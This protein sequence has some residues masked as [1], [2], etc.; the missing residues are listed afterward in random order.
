LPPDVVGNAAALDVYKFLRLQV[1]GRSL[2]D[3]AIA[4]ETTLAAALSD[5]A[6]LAAEWMA[7]FAT[8]P[9]P[10]GQPATHKLAKQ[11]YWPLGEK[12]YHLLA[13]LFP[14][15]LVQVMWASIREDRFSDEAK[16]A[17][18]AKWENRAHPQG[19]RE[20][21]D[22]AIQHFGG[23]KPQNIS[24]LNSER[25]GE[26]WLLPSLPPTW[27]SDPIRPPFFTESAFARR[28]G[29]RVAVK[30]LTR[31]LR[32]FLKSVAKADSNIRIRNKRAEL[33]GYIRDE[34]FQFAAE[35]HELD[36]GWSQDQ[37]CRLN[38]AEQCWLDSKRA[39]IDEEFAARR[40][41]G[42]WQ[43]E[44]CLRFSNWLNAALSA[45]STPMGQA[46]S[47]AWQAVLEAELRSMR[48]ELADHD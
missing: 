35:L 28:F 13:P 1:D 15:S 5:D 30:Q 41:R 27:Q 37:R 9:D 33:V 39:A 45:D 23:T 4:R 17:R 46:E 44:V 36:A 40:R 3:R 6:D 32:E 14:T 25:H 12:Q 38:A 34:L 43:D 7:A 10:N 8:L 42:D 18:K 16:A 47:E 22:L 2:L 31:V 20:Y 26:N 19:Y 48:L 24:Q 11:I 29:N 21:P